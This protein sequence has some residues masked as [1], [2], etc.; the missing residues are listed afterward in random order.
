MAAAVQYADRV[1]TVSPT[2]AEQIKTIEYGEKIEGL[3]SFISN[4]LSGIVNGIDTE[5]NDPSIDKALVKTFDA[6]TL[7][8]RAENKAALLALPLKIIFPALA[9][10][11]SA[12][13]PAVPSALGRPASA[14]SSSSTAASWLTIQACVLPAV[15][16]RR[17]Q[18]SMPK[19]FR[20]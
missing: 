2:Y 15:R 10:Y 1:N 6:N 5:I 13:R 17:M 9:Y 14:V 19:S 8:N 4:R 20:R 7:E 18:L 16:Q 3:L 12:V 11:S